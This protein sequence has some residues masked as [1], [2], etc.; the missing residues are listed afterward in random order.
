V[1]DF[2]LG[3]LTIEARE[4]ASAICL[5]WK[6]R[7]TE[8]S[9]RKQ[10]EPFFDGLFTAAIE[11]HVKLE[12]RF[13]ALEHLNSSTISALVWVVRTCREK[14]IGLVI[15]FDASQT[16]QMLCFDSLRIFQKPDGLL[17]FRAGS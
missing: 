6:G 4:E 7:S 12:L 2:S 16:W 8:R 14:Q 11:R 9:V 15:A 1:H 5:E 10:L 3:D 17:T 13:H